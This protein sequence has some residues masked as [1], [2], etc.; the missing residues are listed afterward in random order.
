MHVWEWRLHGC[1]KAKGVGNWGRRRCRKLGE[2][3]VSEWEARVSES[4]GGEGV[5]IW[6]R[7]GCRKLGEARVSKT[8]GGEMF[9]WPYKHIIIVELPC[10]HT[11]IVLS[12]QPRD[13]GRRYYQASLPN[14]GAEARR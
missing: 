12:L 10:T 14:I 8:R 4:G 7:R 5:G 3:K 1:G 13:Y 9:V 6:G 2:A 11:R